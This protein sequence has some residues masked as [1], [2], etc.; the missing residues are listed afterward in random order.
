MPD[1]N[2]LRNA[3]EQM[4]QSF[5]L[6][7]GGL[8]DHALF[9]T[10]NF[11]PGFFERNVLPLVCGIS[12][13]DLQTKSVDATT[14]EMFYPLKQTRVVVAYDQSVMQGVSGGGLRYVLLPRQLEAGFFH[15]KLVVLAGRDAKGNALVTVMVSSG[16]L[17]LSGWA[18]N[19]EVAAWVSATQKDAQELI[20][21]YR[22]LKE[23]D[24]LQTGL[25][26][27][28]S[29]AAQHSGHELFLQYPSHPGGSLFN[30]LFTMPPYENM[31]I[32]SPYW[33]EKAVRYFAPKGEVICYPAL[34]GERGFSFP[35][36]AEHLNNAGSVINLRAIKGEERFRHAKAY[37]WGNHVAV[38]SANCTWQALHTQ[39]N[40]EAMLRFDGQ[41]LA[42]PASI[43]LPDWNVDDEDEEGIKPCPL[44]VLIVAN[45]D[46]RSYQIKVDVNNKKLCEEWTLRVGDVHLKQHGDLNKSIDFEIGGKSVARQFRLEWLGC[47]GGGFMTGMIIPIGGTDVEL[48]YRPKRSL[49]RI[50]EDM[51]R[52]RTVGAET[53]KNRGGRSLDASDVESDE[54]E[55]QS[56]E[57]EFE[58]DMYGMY[59]SFFHLRKDVDELLA[60]QGNDAKCAEI[61]DTLLEILQA[62]KDGEVSNDL[63]RWLMVQECMELAKLMEAAGIVNTFASLQDGLQEKIKSMLSDDIALKQYKIRPDDMLDWVRKELNYVR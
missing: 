26:I 16:N 58:F 7:N 8:I 33:S 51:L 22:W 10:F 54:L 9:T 27:L 24:V 50:L 21:F 11:D 59:Q 41:S 45:Y 5:E 6:E 53:G 47:D 55:L 23:P 48:G 17:T 4:V 19:I 36:A 1:I 61:A 30:R 40:V 52:H 46:K 43:C 42:A 20:G 14:R 32:Y 38:G 18:D 2:T 56:D 28:D 62:V 44:Q 60:S 63:Q 37:A 12:I 35:V 39:N 15:A 31:Q 13:A 49:D 25:S 3:L 57:A 34:V 29:I